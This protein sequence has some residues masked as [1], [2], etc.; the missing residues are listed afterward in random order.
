MKKNWASGEEE[1]EDEDE[2]SPP[3]TQWGLEDSSV[4]VL[5]GS[6]TWTSPNSGWEIVSHFHE[7]DLEV[8]ACLVLHSSEPLRKTWPPPANEEREPLNSHAS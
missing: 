5:G 3:E 7:D 8:S 1:E 6:F 2:L 4:Q